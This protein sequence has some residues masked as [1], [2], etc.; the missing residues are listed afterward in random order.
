M[1]YE[2]RP[3]YFLERKDEI[4]KTLDTKVEI[5]FVEMNGNDR[6]PKISIIP[7]IPFIKGR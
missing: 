6:E 2:D 1:I 4:E 7:L 5:M 3:D